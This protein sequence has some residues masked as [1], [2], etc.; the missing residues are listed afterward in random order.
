MGAV[1]LT[2]SGAPARDC[3]SAPSSE[4]QGSRRRA[5]GTSQARFGTIRAGAL[6]GRERLR[7]TSASLCV[8]RAPQ[9]HGC[10]LATSRSWRSLGG[11]ASMP[12]GFDVGERRRRTMRS[13]CFS[14]SP[15]GVLRSRTKIR[16]GGTLSRRRS[17]M[18]GRQAARLVVSGLLLSN[19]RRRWSTTGYV[20]ASPPSSGATSRS[21]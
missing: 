1:S 16:P 5:P 7:A 9:A 19:F 12:V 2:T 20:R 13:R 10:C 11:Y 6:S 3:R 4:A 15:R 21:S 8:A 17:V 18:R 14:S